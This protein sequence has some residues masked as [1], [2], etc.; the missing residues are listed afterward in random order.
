MSE[1]EISNLNARIEQLKDDV[2]LQKS[3]RS[4]Y[5]HIA[6]KYRDYVFRM[7]TKTVKIL[8]TENFFNQRK[9]G[10]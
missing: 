5:E 8:K 7:I 6:G 2:E 10:I 9:Y 3:R 1:K 4:H